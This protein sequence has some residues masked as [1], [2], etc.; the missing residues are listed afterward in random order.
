MH[1]SD[2]NL[3]FSAEKSRNVFCGSMKIVAL[4]GTKSA[5]LNCLDFLNFEVRFQTHQEAKP[6]NFS[7]SIKTEQSKR[8]AGCDLIS[9]KI[10]QLI[11][12]SV[13]EK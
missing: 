4:L 12:K 9:I 5:H 13:A 3:C 8:Q 6:F 11:F 7:R 2:H 1:F 10:S